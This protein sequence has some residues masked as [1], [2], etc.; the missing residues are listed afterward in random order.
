M[1]LVGFFNDGLP[2]WIESNGGA[3]KPISTVFGC[4]SLFTRKKA[5]LCLDENRNRVYWQLSVGAALLALLA[6]V[7]G[8]QTILQPQ[9]VGKLSTFS[10]WHMQELTHGTFQLLSFCLWPSSERGQREFSLVSWWVYTL[11]TRA[12][13]AADVSAAARLRQDSAPLIK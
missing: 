13:Q 6:V 2:A 3:L 12:P 5:C 4:F 7:P 8:A 10:M 9:A 1:F 11:I